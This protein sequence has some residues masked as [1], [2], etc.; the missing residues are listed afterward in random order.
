MIK[1]EIRTAS[2]A[3]ALLDRIARNCG[4]HVRIVAPPG[5]G[6]TMLARRIA[7]ALPDMTESEAAAQAW[8]WSAASMGH[9]LPPRR[10]LRAPHHSCS[11]AAITGGGPEGAWRPGE[12]SLAH[13]GV[14][15]LDEAPEFSLLV[16]REVTV[17]VNRG[18]IHT[19]LGKAPA[20]PW[21]VVVRENPCPGAHGPRRR[22][23]CRE[24]RITRYRDRTC[25]FDHL[26]AE[27]VRLCWS[28]REAQRFM[29]MRQVA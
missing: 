18:Q 6:A 1:T 10:P 12:V 19:P 24:D 17:A 5:A 21:C 7:A 23:D 11:R 8:V 26:L 13:G 20:A 22:C 3:D 25:G 28:Q 29:A 15:L 27:E 2:D 16:L 14:L 4:H 9:R